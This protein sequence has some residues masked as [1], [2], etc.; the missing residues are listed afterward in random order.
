MRAALIA[1]P[2]LAAITPPA[3]SQ[4]TTP[5]GETDRW[6]GGYQCLRD[7]MRHRAGYEWAQVTGINSYE[8][9]PQFEDKSFLLGC[10]V[11]V[12]NP[13]RDPNFDDD[14]RRIRRR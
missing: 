5:R 4:S 11:Y 7:C 1:V 2:L 3:L 10:R 14:D 12:D 13:Y 9:C 8:E 6:F